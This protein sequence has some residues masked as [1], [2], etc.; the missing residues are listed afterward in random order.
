MQHA[1]ELTIGIDDEFLYVWLMMILL[2]PSS[3][4]M[5]FESTY[6]YECHFSRGDT[7]MDI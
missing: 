7:G 4:L 3:F 5:T 2:C 6:V 1:A